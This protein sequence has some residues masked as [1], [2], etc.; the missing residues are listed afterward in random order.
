MQHRVCITCHKRSMVTF[1]AAERQSHLAHLSVTVAQC[2]D[3]LAHSSCTATSRRSF[4]RT[5]SLKASFLENWRRPPSY[6]VDEDY[7]A[8]PRLW[9]NLPTEIWRRGTTFGHYRQL[10]KAFCSFRL[11]C[12]V[13]FYLSAPALLLTHLKS[14]NLSLIEAIDVAQN[15]PLWRLMSTFGAIHV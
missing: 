8:R 11:R 9:N 3:H 15:R 14:S 7:P 5:G 1:P 10:L 13:I 6:C 12:I 2:Y 4:A